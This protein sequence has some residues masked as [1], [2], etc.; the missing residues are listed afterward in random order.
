MTITLAAIET[1]HQ[2]ITAMIAAFVAQAPR[3]VIVQAAEIA[4]HDGEHY[5]GIII[6]KDGAASYHLILLAGEAEE[7]NWTDA[8]AWAATVGGELPT[9]REQALLYANLKEEFKPNW[10]WSCEQHA[11]DSG[12]A[13]YQVFYDGGQPHGLKSYSGRARAVR[14]LIIL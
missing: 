3:S 2:K 1:A 12:Y 6:G 8:Q 7:I 11:T 14:R 5:A 9:R 13:W 4:L 10:H